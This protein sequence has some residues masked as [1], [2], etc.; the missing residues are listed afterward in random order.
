MVSRTGA[1]ELECC[2]LG[3]IAQD[4]PCTAYSV[5]KRLG[6]SL[7]SYWSSSTG[8]IYPLLERL[9]ARAW[10]TVTEGAFGSRTRK[11]YRITTSGREELGRWLSAPVS[12]AAAAHT[13]DPLRTPV[14]FLDLVDP[15][16]ARGYLED[17]E[18]RTAE[19]L[20][21]HRA[22]LGEVRLES[23]PYEILGREGAMEELEA[24]LKWLRRGLELL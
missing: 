23:S 20:A 24:R 9:R 7:S 12:T 3:F 2:V 15:V 10:I 21:K 19:N 16:Q 11:T 22:E 14:F 5:R 4:Q 6:A 8:S 1:T 18:R 17:A 13:Y